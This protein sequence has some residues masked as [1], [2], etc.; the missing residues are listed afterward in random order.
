MTLPRVRKIYFNLRGIKQR[1]FDVPLA[2][3]KHGKAGQ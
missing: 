2:V 3:I 1:W